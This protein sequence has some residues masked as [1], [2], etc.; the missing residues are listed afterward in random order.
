MYIKNLTFKWAFR[1]SWSISTRAMLLN[2]VD[3][4]DEHN[5]AVI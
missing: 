2:F 1:S 5:V 3:F 4:S